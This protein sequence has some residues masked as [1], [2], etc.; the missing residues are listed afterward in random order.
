MRRALAFFLLALAAAAP[1]G[2]Q[3]RSAVPD[4]GRNRQ[5]FLDSRW[6]D[7]STGVERRL[8]EPIRR[9]V[10]IRADEPADGRGVAYSVEIQD[11]NGTPIPGFSERESEEIFGDRLEGTLVWGAERAGDLAKLA[12]RSVRLRFVLRDADLYSFRFA[13]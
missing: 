3:S 8:H 13:D 10:A 5:L 1:G 4:I 12:G 2:S 11:E 7:K 6:L 9:E